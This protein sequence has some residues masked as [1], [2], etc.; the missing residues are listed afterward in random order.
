VSAGHFV[1]LCCCLH[2]EGAEA[3][4]A[5]VTIV[6]LTEVHASD[7]TTATHRTVDGHTNGHTNLARVA[8]G[9]AVLAGE[10]LA[11]NGTAPAAPPSPTGRAVAISVGLVQGVASKVGHSLVALA[12]YSA[13][14][15]ADGAQRMAA[16]PAPRPVR[17]PLERARDR[18][19]HAVAAA[20]HT[21]RTTLGAGRADALAFL[22]HSVE[23]GIDWAEVRVVPRIVDDLVPHLVADVVPRIIDG[24]MPAIR[25]RVLPE[26]IDSLATDPRVRDMVVEQSRGVLDEATENLREGTAYADDRVESIARRLLHRPPT[27]DA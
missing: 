24:A 21:G 7:P 20:E 15:A 12:D 6:N 18:V 10:R 1:A 11:A 26:V 23:D 22:Q 4:E 16:L 13:R 9:L 17:V 25:D 14:V 5:A 3:G 19:A 8:L 27:E 2:R